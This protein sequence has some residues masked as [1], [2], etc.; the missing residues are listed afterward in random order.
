MGRLTTAA[1]AGAFVLGLAAG[2]ALAFECP[3]LI[4]Q[5]N[6]AA[7]N[8]M[9][10][11]GTKAKALAAEAEALHKAGKHADAVKKAEEG[12]KTIGLALKH[13]K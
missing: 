8:R 6:D 2:P 5:I 10:D 3:L 13:R 11:A 7:G 1:L 4:K 12:A 9:D